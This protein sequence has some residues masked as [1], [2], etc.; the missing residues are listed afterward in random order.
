MTT[1]QKC[2][3]LVSVG[4]ICGIDYGSKL[5]GTTVLAWYNGQQFGIEQSQPKADADAW[6]EKR[7]AELQPEAIFLDAPLSLPAVYA[8]QGA[9]DY[10]YRQADRELQCMSPMFLGG[11]T[12]RAMRL[13]A[14]W[15]KQGFAVY[16]AYPA[17]VWREIGS[18]KLLYKKDLADLAACYTHCCTILALPFPE[19][20]NWHQFD[21][22]LALIT[23][24]RWQS[25]A[26]K[27]YGHSHEGQIYV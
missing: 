27:C 8:Q 5:A 23:A 13:A 19:P 12:A 4:M 11:L 26:V 2:F 18:S 10:F 3:L 24:L 16:E 14:Q 25:G 17:A 21:A 15:R 22:L 1:Q 7:M 6:L 9:D 20:T